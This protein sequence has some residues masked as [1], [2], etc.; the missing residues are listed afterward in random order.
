MNGNKH[1]LWRMVDGAD[2]YFVDIT[3]WKLSEDLPTSVSDLNFISMYTDAV[4][5]LQEILFDEV[6]N[7]CM[8]EASLVKVSKFIKENFRALQTRV[9]SPRKTLCGK[10]RG[11]QRLRVK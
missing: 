4:H 1:L 11:V 7:G 8:S 2:V 10:Q 3:N 6:S 9:V 5:D